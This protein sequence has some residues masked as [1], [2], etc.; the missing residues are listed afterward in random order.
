MKSLKLV[1]VAQYSQNSA[2]V[3][4]FATFLS[5]KIFPL[6]LCCAWFP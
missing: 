5:Q 2:K 1:N 4:N 3:L 6:R